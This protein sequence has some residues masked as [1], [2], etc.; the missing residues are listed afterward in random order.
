MR[1]TKFGEILLNN[2]LVL[3]KNVKVMKD[4]DWGTCHRFEETKKIKWLNVRQFS[5]LDPATEIG[6]RRETGKIWIRSTV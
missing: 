1:Q 4:K 3:L 5:G 2:W 6:I